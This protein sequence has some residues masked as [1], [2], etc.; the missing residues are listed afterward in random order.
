MLRN[1]PLARSDI[2][3]NLRYAHVL[4]DEIAR[5]MEGMTAG[6]V[7]ERHSAARNGK[8]KEN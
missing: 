3:S 7:P 1:A 5:G 2:K 8:R 4:G 6:M